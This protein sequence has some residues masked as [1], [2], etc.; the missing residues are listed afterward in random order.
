MV[1]EKESKYQDEHAFGLR[2][3]SDLLWLRRLKSVSIKEG[4]Y[5]P[6]SN[7]RKFENYTSNLQWVDDK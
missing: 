1:K 4:V 6:H 7:I 5:V 3:V 2:Y